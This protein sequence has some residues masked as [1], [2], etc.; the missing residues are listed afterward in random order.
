MKPVL[1]TLLALGAAACGAEARAVRVPPPAAA[2]ADAGSGPQAIVLAGGCFWGM[3]GVFEHVKGVLSAV[4][5]YDGG[6]RRFAN[7]EMVSTGTTGHAESVKITYDPGQIS[8]GDILR[9]YFSVATDPTQLDR[10]FPDEGPQYRGEIFYENTGQRDLAQSYIA[11][12]TAAHVFR[13]RIATKVAPDSGFFP[14][15]G[16]HQNYLEK[17]PDAPYIVSYDLPKLRDLKALFPD[18]WRAAPVLAS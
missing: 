8:L 12:L 18:R 10:Q 5:G 14:A 9:I 15:E 6:P 4:A 16:Y 3:Q 11:Q 1:A 2:P 7:Y 13:G 17:H